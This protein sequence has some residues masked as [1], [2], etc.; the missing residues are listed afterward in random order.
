M[1]YL[2]RVIRHPNVP[3]VVPF[4]VFLLFLALQKAIPLPAIVDGPV[5]LI[6]LTAVLYVF[7]RRV[8]DLHATALAPS[9]LIGIAVFIVWILPDLLFPQYRQHW[10]FQNGVMGSLGSSL[11]A[12]DRLDTIVIGSRTLRA[13]VLVP[14]IE[15]LFWRA[16][17]MR[18]LISPT[19]ER[20]RLGT[21]QAQA[22]WI[23]AILFASEHGPFWDVGLIAGI[24]FNWWM[25]RT[26]SLGDCILAHAVTNACLYGYVL[27]THRWEYW[28]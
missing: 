15:E 2:Q 12:A 4:A 10:L 22:F 9:T 14:I 7:S 18:W 28:L 24:A 23:T 16:W 1:T 11:P 3:Y 19:F 13:V 5:R 21:Y 8:I 27:A 6:L 17:L 20:V 26:R 25:V